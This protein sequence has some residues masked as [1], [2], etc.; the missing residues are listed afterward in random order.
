MNS[1]ALCIVY[2]ITGQVVLF[3][4]NNLRADFAAAKRAGGGQEA[5]TAAARNAA[6]H[7]A[8]MPAQ[9]HVHIHAND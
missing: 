3:T 9:A 4:L 1:L 6:G 8:L 5:H 7:V 2:M